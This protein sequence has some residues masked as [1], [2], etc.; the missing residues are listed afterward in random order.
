MRLPK[1]AEGF[2]ASGVAGW[3]TPVGIG[4]L[5]GSEA[6]VF[7]AWQTWHLASKPPLEEKHFNYWQL[8][9]MHSKSKLK[10]ARCQFP[11]IVAFCFM[12][13][14]VYVVIWHA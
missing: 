9:P 4:G 10:C 6:R 2:G 1:P 8:F 13:F 11:Q 3:K 12:G 5:G 7:A 14:A